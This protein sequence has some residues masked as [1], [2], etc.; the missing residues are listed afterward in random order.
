M[1]KSF[2]LK[3]ITI[4]TK[5]CS[6]IVVVGVICIGVKHVA[7]C[8]RERKVYVDIGENTIQIMYVISHF[9]GEYE[10]YKF[11]TYII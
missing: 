4:T 7:R 11:L 3:E 1:V 9:C 10:I 2:I 6:G 8:I 5:I